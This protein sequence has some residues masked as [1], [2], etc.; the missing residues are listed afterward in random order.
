MTFIYGAYDEDGDFQIPGTVEGGVATLGPN[1]LFT[2][3][4]PQPSTWAMMLLGFAGFGLAGY[5]TSRKR[6][7]A[8]A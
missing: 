7:G 2:S 6:G 3:T 5:R 8:T 1:F 4:V